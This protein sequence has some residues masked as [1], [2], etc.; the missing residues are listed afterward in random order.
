MAMTENGWGKERKK[1]GESDE[2]W[3]QR[4]EAKV[5]AN[6]EHYKKAFN[7]ATSPES[8]APYMY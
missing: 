2:R 6:K 4:S 7:H 5:F 3:V 1:N 8:V